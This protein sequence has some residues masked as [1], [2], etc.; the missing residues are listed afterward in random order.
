MPFPRDTKIFG[1][2][3]ADIRNPGTLDTII[4]DDSGRLRILSPDKKYSWRSRD[5]FGGTGI[6]YDTKKKKED[7]FRPQDSPPWRQYITG[8]ILIKDLDGDGISE[9][10]VNKNEFLS[11]TLVHRV[12]AFEKGAIHDLIWAEDTLTTNWKTREINGY[13]SDFQ[14]RD[15]DNDGEEELV[16][17]VIAPIEEDIPGL[18]SKKSKSS[19][20]FFKLF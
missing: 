7:G 15:A 20:Y 10:I 19:I 4:L 16:V 3:V 9:L 2:T 17:S 1:V 11:G 18:L 5:R 13:L 6:F 12:R 14:I 8:R